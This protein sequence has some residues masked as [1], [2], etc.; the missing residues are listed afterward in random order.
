MGAWRNLEADSKLQERIPHNTHEIG[1]KL[2]SI[3]I[4]DTCILHAV[5]ISDD[6]DIDT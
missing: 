5:T 2:I 6:V 4:Y 1:V 3:F